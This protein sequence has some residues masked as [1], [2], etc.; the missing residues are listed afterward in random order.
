MRGS[1]PVGRPKRNEARDILKEEL[2]RVGYDVISAF[3]VEEGA[4]PGSDRL[5]WWHQNT[6]ANE[7]SETRR[8]Q[9]Y[10]RAHMRIAGDL[11][12]YAG[13]LLLDKKR[14]WLDRSVMSRC[15]RDGHIAFEGDRHPQFVLTQKGREW[16]DSGE[17]KI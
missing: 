10:L 17:P 5:E 13:G 11:P 12:L 2:A 8:S 7:R 1:L 15:E 6:P 16:L 14:L 3:Q 9:G 4:R